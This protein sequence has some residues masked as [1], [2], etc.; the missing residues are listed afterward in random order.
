MS[1]I[2]VEPTYVILKDE[3]PLLVSISLTLLR[4]VVFDRYVCTMHWVVPLCRIG[5]R[6]I[7]P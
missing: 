6:A 2:L 5:I 4:Y 7:W 1:G 3:L